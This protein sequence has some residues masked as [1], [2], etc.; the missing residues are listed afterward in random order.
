MNDHDHRGEYA[1]DRHD[2]DLEYAGKH[3]RHYDDER[4]LEELRGQVRELRAILIEFGLDLSEAQGRIHALEA[5]NERLTAVLTSLA[6][7]YTGMA[8][9]GEASDTRRAIAEELSGVF[10]VLAGALRSG[11]GQQPEPEPEVS[12]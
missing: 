8:I 1:D 5:A 4:A 10:H 6:S 9:T 7:G 12:G 11:P 3:H 2:H